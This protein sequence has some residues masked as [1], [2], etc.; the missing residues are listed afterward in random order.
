MHWDYLLESDESVRKAE[1]AWKSSPEDKQLLYRLFSEKFKM[2]DYDLMSIAPRL[3][4]DIE[5]WACGEANAPLRAA[6]R[7]VRSTIV[8]V[9][10]NNF[11]D[12]EIMDSSARDTVCRNRRSGD[13]PIPRYTAKVHIY[14][15]VPI[16]G[17]TRPTSSRRLSFSVQVHFGFGG[18]RLIRLRMVR[19]RF[20]LARGPERVE[21]LRRMRSM[22]SHLRRVLPD[23]SIA[24]ATGPEGRGP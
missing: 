1:R 19:S 12:L 17:R 16:V 9:V 10:L 13:L 18:Q 3:G 24:S 15:R 20:N 22:A 11:D 5:H 4:K 8:G 21:T 14:R 2:G 6:A 23:W 7:E